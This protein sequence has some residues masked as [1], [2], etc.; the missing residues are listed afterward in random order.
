MISF[1]FALNDRVVSSASMVELLKRKGIS[2]TNRRNKTGLSIDPCGT[3]CLTGFGSDVICPSLTNCHR[4]LLPDMIEPDHAIWLATH[5]DN[6][7]NSRL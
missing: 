1:Q 2:F 3:P 5:T 4:P 7:F 6:F